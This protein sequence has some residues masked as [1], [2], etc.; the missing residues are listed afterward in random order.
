MKEQIQLANSVFAECAR[1]S[2]L[3]IVDSH[4]GQ[5]L[6]LDTASD[7]V[8]GRVVVT[9]ETFLPRSCT[10]PIAEVRLDAEDLSAAEPRHLAQIVRAR[11]SEAKQTLIE[12]MKATI[13]R[14]EAC[15]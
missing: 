3:L 6:L 2:G 8:S 10:R 15:P 9:F 5:N 13:A 12:Q 1:A 14:L 11:V 7:S 4:D